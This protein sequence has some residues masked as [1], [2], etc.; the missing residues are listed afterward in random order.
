MKKTIFLLPAV[1]FSIAVIAFC[2][3]L[4][5]IV[6]LWFLW[7][8]FL[9]LGS[10][11]LSKGNY[12]GSVVGLIP[13]VHMIYMSTQYTGQTVSI[14]LPLGAAIAICYLLLGLFVWKNRQTR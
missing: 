9:W 6:P 2:L 11:L 5:T 7:A 14:E 3:I 13:A 10:Y 1:L 12:L 8:V 4:R